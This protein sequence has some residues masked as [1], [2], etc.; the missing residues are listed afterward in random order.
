MTT[1]STSL[2]LELPGDGQQT[3]TWGQT[4][5]KNLG[6][7]LEQ[8]ITGVQSIVMSNATYTLTNLNGTVDEARNAILVVTGTNSAQRDIVAPL[9]NKIYTVKNAT[10]GGFA[11]QI[12]GSSGTGAVIP[13]GVTS[14]VF[15]D[16]TNFYPLAVNTAGNLTVNGTLAVTG[17]TTLTGA[18]GGSTAVFSGAISSVSPAFTGTPTAPTATLGTNTTQI[19]STA[20]VQAAT[21]ALG[22]MSTQNANNVNITGGV[23]SGLSSVSATT[24][25]GAGTGLTGTAS[26]LS[27]GG[28]AA[29]VTNGVVT[30]GAYSNPSW[31]TSLAGGKITG[32]VALA[33]AATDATNSTNAT[34]VT[35]ATQNNI[36]SIPHLAT[37]GTVTT[38]TWSGLFGAV[39][40]ANLTNLNANNLASGTVPSARLSGTYNIN[41]SGNAATAT[42]ATSATNLTGGT[43]ACSSGSITSGAP[44]LWFYDTDQADF[45]CHV[46]SNLWYVLN[47]GGSG[48]FYMDQSGNTTANG[49]I[50]AYSDERLKTNWRSVQDNFVPQLASIKS[51]VFE[52]TDIEATQVGVSAQSLQTLMPEA[53]QTDKDGMLTVNYGAA[54][55]VAA[56]ELAK[57]VELLRAELAELKRGK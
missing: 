24:F 8:A 38:G 7:L 19:A 40:G 37:V 45:A 34:T 16:G 6:T 35:G 56:I 39:S 47:Q 57:E 17:A 41:V 32:A 30:T 52:R 28:N 23:I 50:T 10:T 43:M 44:T 26:A 54:A 29:T 15:C 2:K 48:I 36:T 51:G 21:G 1:Y 5:N 4:T 31:I 3:G 46:N 27:I 14:S 13:N 53:V 25:T 42:S 12:I 55:L 33:T 49:N 9:V 22:T 11:I 18:L 20:F